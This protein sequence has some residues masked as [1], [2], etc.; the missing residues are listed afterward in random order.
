MEGH[1]QLGVWK[2]RSVRREILCSG[3]SAAGSPYSV[4]REA[5]V[6]QEAGSR[7]Q[8]P[9]VSLRSRPEEGA[10]AKEDSWCAGKSPGP[11][12]C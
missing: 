3:F 5:R 9:E 2:G 7:T 10:L 4:L 1:D 8:G 12:V 11:R 6:W